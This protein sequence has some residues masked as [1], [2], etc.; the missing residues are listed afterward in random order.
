[1]IIYSTDEWNNESRKELENFF[2]N[3]SFGPNKNFVKEP[4][5]FK[6]FSYNMY[7][8]EEDEDLKHQLLSA[9]IMDGGERGPEEVDV[10]GCFKSIY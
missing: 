10:N 8:S 9:I 7:I 3:G 6:L 4:I 2:R 1:M 5:T